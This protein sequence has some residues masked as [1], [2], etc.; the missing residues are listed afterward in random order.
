MSEI[1]KLIREFCEEKGGYR[2]EKYSYK[3]DFEEG[4]CL[5]V[6]VENGG[7]YMEMMM[8]LT[9]YLEERGY[10]D[11]DMRLEGMNAAELGS[12]TI[13]YFPNIVE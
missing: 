9:R 6:V 8:D 1:A 4:I 10:D 7:S 13:V 3:N 2:I 5:G 11:A 12:D